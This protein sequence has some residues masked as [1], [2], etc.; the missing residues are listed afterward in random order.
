MSN[1]RTLRRISEV[2]LVGILTRHRLWLMKERNGICAD[3]SYMDLSG[4]NL[5]HKDLRAANLSYSNFEGASLNY[6]RACFVFAECSNFDNASLG[7]CDF[8]GAT[9][10]NSTFRGSDLSYSVFNSAILR[11]VNLEGSNIAFAN[12][13]KSDLT[14]DQLAAARRGNYDQ[15]MSITLLMQRAVADKNYPKNSN[16]S[17]NNNSNRHV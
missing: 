17:N 6:A 1:I 9:F 11:R 4:V 5:E 13:L 15:D 2:E 3:L 10:E 14:L 8:T 7:S 16:D 12:L